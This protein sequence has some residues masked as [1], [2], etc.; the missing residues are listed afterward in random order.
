MLKIRSTLITW[1]A[2]ITLASSTAAT[3][4][5]QV[6]VL[7]PEHKKIT[8]AKTGVKLTFLTTKPARDN[9]L[10]FHQRS[11]LAD[12][13]VILFNSS[14]DRGGLMGYLVQTGELLRFATPKGKLG[15]ATA[16][17]NGAGFYALRGRE[18]LQ[19]SLKTDPSADPDAK[20]ST[21]TL[22]ER[23]ICNIPEGATGTGLNESCDG[24]RL[25]IGLSGGEV[26]GDPA[27]FVIDVA[28]GDIRELCRPPDPPGYAY[29]VQ[30]SHTDP[31]MLSYAGSTQRLMVVDIRDGV[32][33]NIY[34][35]IP[36]E[37]VTHESWWVD[38]QMIFCGGLHPYP[39]EDAHVKVIDLKTGVVRIIGAGAWW[40]EAK[41]S[42]LAKRNWWHA[43]GSDDGKWVVADNWH[44]DIMLFDAKTTR[45]RLLTAGHRKY[46]HGDH[47][48]VGFD[49]A[50]KAVVFTSHMLGNEDVCVAQIPESWPTKIR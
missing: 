32:P 27:I 38:D 25:S 44:G 13:S 47:P 48:H 9:N 4:Q 29:H 24:K 8:D 6:Q 11:W 46:G 41:P 18:V 34:K 35:A 10:Y 3:A 49:R 7:P 15:G 39:N 20:P 26:C 31:N 50:S 45:P 5:Y 12:G 1:I 23:R 33:R 14:R 43:D 37:L 19:F 17:V 21:A 28:S 2:L 22:T 16:A 30:W 42:E 36:G 40:P